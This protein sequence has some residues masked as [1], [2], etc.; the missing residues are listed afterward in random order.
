MFSLDPQ[1]LHS[2]WHLAG[3]RSWGWE[4]GW[5]VTL[6]SARTL[7]KPSRGSCRAPVL[8]QQWDH[9]AREGVVRKNTYLVDVSKVI[10][11]EQYGHMS[12]SGVPWNVINGRPPPP[13]T[14][15][16]LLSRKFCQCSHEASGKAT[17]D[18]LRDRPT[19][20][21]SKPTNES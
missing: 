11:D 9:E 12:F 5:S 14:V 18:G 2:A 19:M 1:C 3:S 15:H 4:E 7:L 20:P 13:L 10:Q 8:C 6:L 16:D 21:D 17:Q